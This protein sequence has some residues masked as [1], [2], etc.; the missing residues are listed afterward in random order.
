MRCA[1]RRSPRIRA[2]RPT[3]RQVA[4]RIQRYLDGDRDLERRRA[5]GHEQVFAAHA[6]LTAGDRAVAV[7]AAGR[8]LALDPESEYAAALVT[9][10]ILE[11]P[12]PLP[13]ELL[14]AV[15]EEERTM[16]RVR[17]RRGA[18]LFLSLLSVVLFLP[19]LYVASWL[20]LTLLLVAVLAMAATSFLNA[21]TGTVRLRYVVVGMFLLVFAFS[22]LHAPFVM[23]PTLIGGLVLALSSRP[24]V[25]DRPWLLYAFTTVT[26]VVPFGL[27]YLGVFAPTW[28]M[29]PDGLLTWGRIFGTHGD[30]ELAMLWLGNLGL[31]LA[32]TA[33]AIVITRARRN[34]QR[35]T[36]IQAW[37]L[38]H[39]LPKTTL[40]P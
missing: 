4:E 2:A 14:D 20:D 32:L 17:A 29:T 16:M 19:W 11:P 38:R 15:E 35:R 30:V 22:R 27:E 25:L 10:L 37:H 9:R 26:M 24:L 12:E 6:A 21:R 34:A 39:L 7:H 18:G 33:Y 31:T 13:A 28:K 8:A 40:K 3:A 36:Q 23:M 5:L 1:S